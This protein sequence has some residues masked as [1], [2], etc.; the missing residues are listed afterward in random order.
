VAS[1]L[2]ARVLPEVASLSVVPRAW[3]ALEDEMRAEHQFH[4]LRLSKHLKQLDKHRARKKK[5]FS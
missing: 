2:H 1:E 4:G 3:T 5:S